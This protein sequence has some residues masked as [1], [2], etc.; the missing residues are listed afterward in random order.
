MLNYKKNKLTNLILQFEI[1]F[2]E[3]QN[4]IDDKTN[5]MSAAGKF[6]AASAHSFIIPI[7]E[8]NIQSIKKQIKNL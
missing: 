1:A 4:D 5:A 8:R 2:N 3:A 6:S 7:I